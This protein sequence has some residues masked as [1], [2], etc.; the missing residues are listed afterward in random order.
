MNFFSGMFTLPCIITP[1]S[2]TA[3]A[4][5]TSANLNSKNAASG[6]EPILRHQV[7]RSLRAARVERA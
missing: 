3:A 2:R 4:F 7:S 5:A 1:F 6:K